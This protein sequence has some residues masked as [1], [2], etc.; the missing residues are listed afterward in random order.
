M[1]QGSLKKIKIP[2]DM[3]TKAVGLFAVS[4]LFVIGL[5]VIFDALKLDY[6]LY[7]AFA[8]LVSTTVFTRPYLRNIIALT[9]YVDDMAQDKPVEEPDLSFLS[10]EYGLSDAIRHLHTSW[11][12]RRKQLEAMLSEREILVDSLPDLLIMVDSELKVVRTNS[13]ARAQFGQ[14]L[15]YKPL[16]SVI[17]DKGFNVAVRKTLA[18]FKGREIEFY[19]TGRQAAGRYFRVHIERFPVHSPGGISIII[20]LHDITEHKKIEQ[21]LSDFVANASHEIKTPLA[22]MTGFIETLQGPAKEDSEARDKFL[23]IMHEQASRM[24]SLVNDLLSLSRLEMSVDSHPSGKV[25]L[26]QVIDKEI[27][28]EEYQAEQKN[29]TIL[30]KVSEPLPPVKGE[31]NELCQVV[32]NLLSNAVKYG[33]ANTTV[34]IE[35][36]LLARLPAEVAALPWDGARPQG[37]TIRVAISDEGEGISSEHLPRLTERFYRVDTARTRKAGGTGLGLAIVRYVLQRHR[38]VLH[39][40]SEEGQGS[41]FSFY[42]PIYE[43]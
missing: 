42:L 8:I 16:S 43:E 7:A 19:L 17:Q 29:V 35:A 2:P 36:E 27:R 9:R 18:D 3:L 26:V 25:D 20:S 41:T 15:A 37:K 23:S 13:S 12:Q 31:M 40:E 34:T 24:N 6:A 4:P 22:S 21:M 10:M 33:G 11:E 5:Y 14:N 28:H 38:G 30:R 39:I 32:Q 1:A